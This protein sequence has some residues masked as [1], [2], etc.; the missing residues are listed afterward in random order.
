MNMIEGREW[1]GSRLIRR[2]RAGLPLSLVL[3][4]G[5][6]F[7]V[8]PPCAFCDT[9][10]AVTPTRIPVELRPGETA[11]QEIT[12]INQGTDE[13]SLRPGITKLL[14]DEGGALSFVQDDSC[15]WLQPGIDELRLAPGESGAFGFTLAVPPDADPGSYNLAVTF[16]PS[17]GETEGIGLSGGVAVLID[18]EVLPGEEREGAAGFPTALV[19]IM[20]VVA[21]ALFVAIAMAAMFKHGR[22][23]IGVDGG[24]GGEEG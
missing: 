22:R 10:I 1:L 23:E 4:A 16:E 20:A 17:K 7:L 9:V 2:G 6:L 15:T 13:T 21:A 5:L 24:E 11:T 3:V 8:M 12:L 19:V 18:L 14:E